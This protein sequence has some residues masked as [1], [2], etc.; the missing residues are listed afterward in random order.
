ME[1]IPR[2]WA[3]VHETRT[4]PG[5]GTF[6]LTIDGASDVSV[7]DAQRDAR[8]RLDAL[9]AAGG[10]A[11]RE[12]SEHEYY[13]SRRLPEE[14]LEEIRSE[15]GTLIAAI[16]RNRYGAAVLNTDV[17]LISDVDLPPESSG[18]SKSAGARSAGEGKRPGLLSRLFGRGREQ[19]DVDSGSSADGRGAAPSAGASGA[20]RDGADAAVDGTGAGA[21]QLPVALGGPGTGGGGRAPAHRPESTRECGPPVTGQGGRA[22]RARPA[23]RRDGGQRSEGEAPDRRPRPG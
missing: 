20:E 14:L 21:A 16:T 18:L 9:I 23:G 8:R 7:E 15:D 12:G 22:G 13:P 10:P 11:Q 6:A 1:P 19:R 4:F 3:A 2:H 5:T 17:L